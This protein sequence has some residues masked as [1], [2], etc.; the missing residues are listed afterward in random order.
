VNDLIMG[1]PVILC[2]VWEQVHQGPG[3]HSLDHQINNQL[4]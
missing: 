1:V 2:E 3:K 4:A